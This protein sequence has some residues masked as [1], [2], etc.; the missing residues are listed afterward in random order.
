MI[1]C[2]LNIIIKF[3]ECIILLE[4]L[5]QHKSEHLLLSLDDYRYA[6]LYF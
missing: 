2:S 6:E 4:L 3:P 5:R 1:V